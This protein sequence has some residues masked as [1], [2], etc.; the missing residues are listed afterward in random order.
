MA[1][2]GRKTAGFICHDLYKRLSGTI[3]EMD[4][5]LEGIEGK[6][7]M[8]GPSGSPHAGGV[9]LLPA[10]I[11]FYGIDP[12]KLPTKAA[13][14]VGK[15]LGDEVIARYIR[16]EGKYPENIGMVFWSGANMRSHGQ[17]I[18]EF[19]YLMG[20][21]PIWEKGSFYVKRLEPIPLRS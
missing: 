17:C 7:I 8:P 12:R 9:S 19:L 18:A 3:Q 4:H 14:A 21:R 13:W 11:N 1:E 16:E 5:T 15:E 2:A 6:Y 20:I 10:G